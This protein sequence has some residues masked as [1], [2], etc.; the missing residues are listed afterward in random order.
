MDAPLPK[1]SLMV[2]AALFAL[3]TLG[4]IVA[5][6][7]SLTR[8]ATAAPASLSTGSS[9][10]SAGITVTGH[11]EVEGVPDTLRLDIGVQVNEASVDA[12]MERANTSSA[13]VQKALRDQGVA[14]K[15][16]QTTQ[17]SVQPQYDWSSNSQRLIGYQVTQTVRA[18]LRDVETA[19]A[20]VS[21]ATSAGGDD[22][23][24]NGIS[25]DLEDNATLLESARARAVEDA[26]ARAS[27][28][29][30]AADRSLGQV[31]SISENV[32]TSPSPV[33]AE[34]SSADTFAGS[35]VPI[36]PGTQ[37][38]TVDVTVIF[39]LR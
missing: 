32:T 27:Q 22:T 6:I 35:E 38:V 11:A 24:I 10:P 16:I 4:L 13:A 39:E 8:P 29:A 20:V 12:A 14:E 9:A 30:S 25:F 1:R 34:R 33:F 18:T 7:V 19:G 26:K 23:V 31:V 28:Y 21:A 17:V 5:L 2:A 15:D 3:L 37:S 36:A